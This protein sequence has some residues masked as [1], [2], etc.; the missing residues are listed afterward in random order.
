MTPL[1]IVS[2][3]SAFIIIVLVIMLFMVYRR[4]EAA[5]QD[6]MNRLMSKDF[7]DFARN[8][9][10]IDPGVIKEK[11]KNIDSIIESDNEEE[12]TRDDLDEVPVV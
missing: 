10:F 2:G 11:K 12:T 9:P 3:M 7:T 8:T 1:L 4:G 5:K 6:L